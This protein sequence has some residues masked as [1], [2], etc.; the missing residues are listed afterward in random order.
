MTA[1]C[2]SAAAVATAGG[3]Y[4]IGIGC[5]AA[6]AR[7]VRITVSLGRTRFR[8]LLLAYGALLCQHT[9]FRAG[10]CVAG[11][12]PVA[13]M[14]AG[15]AHILLA[16]AALLLSGSVIHIYPSY[17]RVTAR[18][19]SATVNAGAVFVVVILLVGSG[20][21][22]VIAAFITQFD[23]H[24]AGRHCCNDC[25]ASLTPKIPLVEYTALLTST[26]SANEVLLKVIPHKI[27]VACADPLLTDSA[28]FAMLRIISVNCVLITYFMS[29][30]HRFLLL[31]IAVRTGGDFGTLL[32]TGGCCCCFGT[33]LV[34]FF[35]AASSTRMLFV[36]SVRSKGMLC[37]LFKGL[38]A[39]GAVLD[40]IIRSVVIFMILPAVFMLT[41]LLPAAV[42]AGVGN[43]AVAIDIFHNVMIYCDTSAP[44]GHAV[45][46]GVAIASATATDV[47]AI[48]QSIVQR[49]HIAVLQILCRHGLPR[50]STVDRIHPA[51][52]LREVGLVNHTCRTGIFVQAVAVNAPPERC[53]SGTFSK[54]RIDCRQSLFLCAGP[55]CLHHS[56]RSPANGHSA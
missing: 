17:I 3:G 14:V 44:G 26:C 1:R 28:I 48:G 18:C 40:M 34:A 53:Q 36:A 22:E 16:V 35:I 10:S 23:L 13:F 5:S 21:V 42:L 27:V 55:W 15:N 6:T 47:P 24:F 12:L 33:Q 11:L 2:R 43:H 19:R 20:G 7:S 46:H 51:G 38:L 25:S 50:E 29:T 31:I 37:C 9:V 4:I 39:L 8:R 45:A 32:Q 52:S 54:P 49:Q 56:I 41:F 30:F